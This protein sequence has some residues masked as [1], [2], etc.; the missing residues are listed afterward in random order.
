ME[1][2]CS[3]WCPHM[4]GGEVGEGGEAGAKA[5]LVSFFIESICAKITH[6]ITNAETH[7]KT[8]K[9]TSR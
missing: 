1:E 7:N 4:A 2:M 6:S 9:I 5:S 8:W 3:G